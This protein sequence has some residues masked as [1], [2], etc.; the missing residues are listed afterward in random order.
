MNLQSPRVAPEQFAIALREA[1]LTKSTVSPPS[2]IWDVD[3][4]WA[5]AVQLA[6]KNFRIASGEKVVGA[7][8][9]L[10]SFAKQQAMNIDQ[11]VFGF[12]TDAMQV[13][14]K[15]NR[16]LF[17][18]PR[19]EPELVFKLSRDISQPIELIDVTNYIKEIA[20]GFELI[21]SRYPKFQFTFEDVVADN[22]S[23]SGFAMGPWYPYSGE[24]ISGLLGYIEQDN[25][26]LDSGKLSGLLGNP[27]ETIVALSKWVY[28]M[29]ET[30]SA[31][32][33]VLAGSMT[34]AFPIS[35]GKNYRA[36]IDGLGFL[37]LT[38]F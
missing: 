15:I 2:S 35:V 13:D 21:D 20:V 28:S 22:T 24:N 32:S 10:T 34:N 26:R 37:D 31:D 8:L 6:D 18:Q 9:G 5:Q 23:A 11:P 29:G 25:V 17:N 30:I 1:R 14:L 12:L 3:L 33:I 7:K 27:L 16:E 19:I 38:V 36:G 4:E